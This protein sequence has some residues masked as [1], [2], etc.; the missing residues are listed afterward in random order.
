MLHVGVIDRVGDVVVAEDVG[1]V[2]GDVVLPRDPP[3]EIGR[4][5]LELFG[6]IA[7]RGDRKAEVL[8]SD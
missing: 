1:A 3:D 6:E 8:D 5:L 7:R 4:T 2:H